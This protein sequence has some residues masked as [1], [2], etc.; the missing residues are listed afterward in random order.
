MIDDQGDVVGVVFAKADL[1]AVYRQSGIVL[2]ERAFALPSHELRTFLR[3][4]RVPVH[5][6]GSANGQEDTYTVRID[7]IK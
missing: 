5:A 2:D 4:N 7:C 3:Q 1:P 6:N